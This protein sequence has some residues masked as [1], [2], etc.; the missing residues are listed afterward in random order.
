MPRGGDAI[1][2]QFKTAAVVALRGPGKCFWNV[3][4][5][6]GID[7]DIMSGKFAVLADCCGWVTSTL[8][9]PITDRAAVAV[10]SIA[11]ADRAGRPLH[12]ER[13]RV[14]SRATEWYL[15]NGRY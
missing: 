9:W 1:D 7:L 3:K 5:P 14:F 13:S 8:R 11:A 10:A 12:S 6:Q 4:A 15:R 2:A